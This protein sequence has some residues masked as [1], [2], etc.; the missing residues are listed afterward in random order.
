MT[1]FR[2]ASG[3]LGLLCLAG[4]ATAQTPVL[5]GRNIP[6]D[7]AGGSLL[8]TQRFQTGFGDDNDGGQFG[9]GSE[10]DQLFVTHTSTDLYIGLTGNLQ[11]NGNAIVIFIDVDG[12]NSGA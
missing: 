8:A 4:A 11:N 5:D 6:T 1:G 10:L 3:S 2:T 7:F 12:A 9:F